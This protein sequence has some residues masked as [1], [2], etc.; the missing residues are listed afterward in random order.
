MRQKFISQGYAWAASSYYQNGYDV[1]AGVL[2]TKDLAD[3]FT[4][5]VHRPHRTYITGVSLG[6]HVVGRSLEQFP[7]FYD[8]ALP[9]CGV[10]GD[11]ALFDYFLDYYLVAEDLAGIRAYPV[12]ADFLTNPALGPQ[13][14]ANLGLTALTPTNDTTNDLGKQFRAIMVNRTGGDRP[15]AVPAFAFWK[16]FLFN[17]GVPTVPSS[18]DD[19]LAERPGQLATNILTRYTPNAPVDVNGTV[20]RVPP[21][22]FRPR[23]SP[24]LTQV[25]RIQGRPHA[26]VVSLHGLGDLFV[27]FANEQQY[28]ADAARHGQ[29]HNVVQRAIRTINHCEFSPDEAGRAWDDLVAWVTHGTRPAG[30]SVNKPSV[31]ADPNYGCTF[32]DRAAFT[33]GTGT[34][35]LFAACP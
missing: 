31:V 22:N 20:Q 2:S 29:S 23:L 18:P 3:A 14:Q 6:G 33:A 16:N 8:G 30:D 19:T 32:S 27:P 15:G 35:R 4:K 26:P 7:G 21:E 9:M 13:I 11:Q 17:L 34:R 28:Q 10:L 12:P 24:L 25:P 5:L 1:R